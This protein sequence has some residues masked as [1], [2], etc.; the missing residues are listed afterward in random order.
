[1]R[2]KLAV[3][4]C[5]EIFFIALCCSAAVSAYFYPAR[6]MEAVIG[7]VVTF[8]GCAGGMLYRAAKDK[9]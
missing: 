2:K 6:G 1:M 9:H 3:E 4:I 8:V 7:G 5:T